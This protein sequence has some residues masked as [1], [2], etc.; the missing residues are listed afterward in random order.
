MALE[1]PPPTS[2]WQDTPAVLKQP[3]PVCRKTRKWR[4]EREAERKAHEGER[5][6]A[7]EAVSAGLGSDGGAALTCF[8]SLQNARVIKAPSHP[9]KL[10]S[11][12]GEGAE[13][14]AGFFLFSSPPFPRLSGDLYKN[15]TSRALLLGLRG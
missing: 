7:W 14:K 9:L 11:L 5:S 3:P 4:E 1:I 12:P 10:P 8:G 13:Q 6:V 2:L 15:E